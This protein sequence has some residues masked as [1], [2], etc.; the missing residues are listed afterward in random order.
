[1][2]KYVW[3]PERCYS[4]YVLSKH[5]R[6][7][8][9]FVT[10][11]AVTI[12]SSLRSL[13]GNPGHPAVAG[14]VD[15]MEKLQAACR[16]VLQICLDR[17]W[18]DGRWYGRWYG[19]CHMLPAFEKVRKEMKRNYWIGI[20]TMDEILKHVGSIDQKLN[21]STPSS[22]G[23]YHSS[24]CRSLKHLKH[25]N[26]MLAMHRE[27]WTNDQ[28]E[29]TSNC[30][31]LTSALKQGANDSWYLADAATQPNSV[32]DIRRVPW[33]IRITYD[34]LKTCPNRPSPKPCCVWST[35]TTFIDTEC[36]P[37][38]NCSFHKKK[39]EIRPS[40]AKLR[41]ESKPQ[42][43]SVEE[44]PGRAI[45]CGDHLRTL[46]AVET[47]GHG[48]TIGSPGSAMNHCRSSVEFWE[49][50]VWNRS[51]RLEPHLIGVHT[52]HG[53]WRTARSQLWPGE[54]QK[55]V[56]VHHTLHRKDQA[57]LSPSGEDFEALCTISP[58]RNN[59]K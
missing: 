7:E 4:S 52:F 29:P 59:V 31:T 21:H 23:H 28:N 24:Q 16:E 54:K 37:R 6:I 34:V 55:S 30:R 41:V 57:K 51:S 35:V 10:R 1:M 48:E 40:N 13:R 5:W 17:W 2:F 53:T 33:R 32:G 44:L 20:L 18:S 26:L 22:E 50:C 36:H 27:P 11:Q 42:I 49:F 15:G 12:A 25:R 38:P 56:D 14:P 47:C 46:P 19:R 9:N 58:C 43:I 8:P 3:I 39:T 45:I